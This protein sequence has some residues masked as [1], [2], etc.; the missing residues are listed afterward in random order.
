MCYLIILISF[1]FT[2]LKKYG[3]IIYRCILNESMDIY[4]QK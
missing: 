3:C 4:L 2:D 1:L